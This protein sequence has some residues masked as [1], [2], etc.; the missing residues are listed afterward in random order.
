MRWPYFLGSVALR[1]DLAEKILLY[2]HDTT[3]HRTN[4]GYARFD[5]VQEPRRN[6]S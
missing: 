6:R 5:D 2:W 4:G 3:L 1:E